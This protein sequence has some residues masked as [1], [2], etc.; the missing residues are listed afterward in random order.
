ML[1]QS[2]HGTYTKPASKQ[3]LY[4]ALSHLRD[5]VNPRRVLIDVVAAFEDYLG[6]LVTAVYMDF[7][8]KL[9]GTDKGG[10]AAEDS[11]E[12]R[13]K[14]IKV[15]VTS[16]DKA[17]MLDFIVEEKVRGLFYGNPVA[18][19][20]NDKAK[21]EFRDYFRS[22]CVPQ[23][24]EYAELTATRNVIAHNDGRVDRKY[25]REVKGT[26]LRAGQRIE[27]G[28]EYIR[29]SIGLLEGL[30]AAATGLVLRGIYKEEPQGKVLNAW[31]SFERRMRVK[32]SEV[33]KAAG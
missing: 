6:D 33:P 31:S 12:E 20:K 21:L 15:I 8:G 28:R 18:F 25:L 2:L 30:S 32:P 19:F 10:A 11:A 13:E 1:L 7:P 3:D 17:E 24:A 26:S 22:Q 23:L 4:G 16:T 9:L 14:L 27:L 29:S 5:R